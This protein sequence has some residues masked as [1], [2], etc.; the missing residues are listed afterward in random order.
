[1]LISVKKNNNSGL[2]GVSFDLADLF[3]EYRFAGFFFFGGR[4]AG[5][6]SLHWESKVKKKNLSPLDHSSFLNNN[7]NNNNS[8]D[9]R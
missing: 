1:M 8:R 5:C 7:N 9:S 2:G 3:S 4:L 6:T